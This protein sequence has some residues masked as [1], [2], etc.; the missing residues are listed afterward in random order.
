VEDTCCTFANITDR[1]VP[2]EVYNVGGREEWAISIEELADIVLRATGG[3]PRLA[4]YK[5][6]EGFTTRIKVVD[7]SKA[8]RDLKHDPKIDIHEGVRRYV[9]WA[10]KVYSY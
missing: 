4:R 9:E 8:R 5:G 7:F 6:E 3:S 10:R 1:F 2:G